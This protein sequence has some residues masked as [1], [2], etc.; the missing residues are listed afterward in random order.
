MLYTHCYLHQLLIRSHSSNQ[1]RTNSLVANRLHKPSHYRQA[2][3]H[4]S[5]LSGHTIKWEK[6]SLSSAWS[7]CHRLTSASRRARL[8]SLIGS[9]MFS[10]VKTSA[11]YCWQQIQETAVN[12]DQNQESKARGSSQEEKRGWICRPTPLSLFQ[13]VSRPVVSCPNISALT[14]KHLSLLTCSD[15]ELIQPQSSL[16]D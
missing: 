15:F 1:A 8:I 2:Y 11:K 4:N 6:S 12:G 5:M 3:L 9:A 10:F 14:V 16:W 13:A 7:C